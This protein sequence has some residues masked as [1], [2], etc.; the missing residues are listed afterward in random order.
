MPITATLIKINGT[1]LDHVKSYKVAPNKL[2]A[3]AGRNMSGDLRATFIG[4]FPKITV[5]FTPM[6]SA[7]MKTLLTLLKNQSFTV[8]WYD[9]EADSIKTDTYYAG[10]YEYAIINKALDLYEGFSVNLIPFNK[11]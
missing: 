1:T 10:D 3:D 2:W 8:A 5:E 4:I 7:D 11:E 6:P 9:Q